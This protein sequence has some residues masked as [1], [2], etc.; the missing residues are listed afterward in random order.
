MKKVSELRERISVLEAI[1]L[2]L[3][4]FKPVVNTSCAKISL[5][6]EVYEL[7]NYKLNHEKNAY[8]KA[9]S[10]EKQFKEAFKRKKR[11]ERYK[12]L[13]EKAFLEKQEL[14]SKPQEQTDDLAMAL[15]EIEEQ[16][17]EYQT[18]LTALDSEEATRKF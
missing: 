13:L 11:K 5:Y 8:E 18:I 15:E 12:V 1:V 14:K 3:E 16:I 17:R 9:L 2:M 7:L 10:E 6:N 4:H